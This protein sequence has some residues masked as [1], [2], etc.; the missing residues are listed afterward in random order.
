MSKKTGKASSLL[1]LVFDDPYDADEAKAAVHRMGGEGLL[2]LDETAVVVKHA[3]GKIRMTQDVN[4]VGDRQHTGHVL[5]LLAAAVTGTMPF[6]MAGTLGGRLLGRLTDDGITDK[7]TK[8]VGKELEPGTS[9]L[10]LLVH[11]DPA[12]PQPERRRKVIERLR[13]WNPRVMESDL[14]PELE[15]ELNAALHH[16]TATA[17]AQP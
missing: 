17:D 4:V 2:E 11:A 8:N 16:E 10:L 13:Q 1:A 9:A 6:I 12:N 14:P 7:F 5:G 3:D 15:E